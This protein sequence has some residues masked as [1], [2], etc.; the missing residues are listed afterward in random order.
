MNDHDAMTAVRKVLDGWLQL[1]YTAVDALYEI[2]KIVG[3]NQ[4]DHEQAA[5]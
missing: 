2:S 1:D 4:F 3:A 5:K